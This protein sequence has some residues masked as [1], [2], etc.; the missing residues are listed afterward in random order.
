VWDGV[1]DYD[2]EPAA[3]GAAAARP[4]QGVNVHREE[5]VVT[6][7]PP[8]VHGERGGERKKKE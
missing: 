6:R 5:G 3:T 1:V 2:R 8:I 7:W 4:R